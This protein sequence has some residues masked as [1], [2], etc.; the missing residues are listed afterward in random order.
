MTPDFLRTI[1]ETYKGQIRGIFLY[2]MAPSM[3]TT[4]RNALTNPQNG[5]IILNTTTNKLN[6][7]LNGAWE[8]ITSA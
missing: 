3:T 7:R 1:S 2:F 8:Q 5:M 6:V 4:E